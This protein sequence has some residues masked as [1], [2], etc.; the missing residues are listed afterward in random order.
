VHLSDLSGS[1]LLI[2]KELNGENL[3][4]CPN[5]FYLAIFRLF[6]GIFLAWELP[7][8]DGFWLVVNGG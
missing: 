4:K 5:Y 8:G 6:A 3:A 7:L 2:L 1:G